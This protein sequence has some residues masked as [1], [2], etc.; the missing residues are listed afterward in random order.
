[1]LVVWRFGSIAT[2][3]A[4]LLACEDPGMPGTDAAVGPRCSQ[5]AAFGRITALT[6]LNTQN[7]DEQAA[8]S[9]DELTVYFSRDDNGGG[10]NGDYDIFQATR[11]SKTA[12][13]GA[14]TAVAGV[15]TTTAQ[16]REPR[17]TADGLTMYATTR[18]IPVGAAKFRVAFATRAS[19]ADSF[20]PLQDVPAINGTT[21]NDSDPFIS[22]DGRV[23]Y[24]AS[25][26]GGNYALY[27]SVQTAGV[28]SAPALVMG[29]NLETTSAEIT[30][31]L[32]EDELTL[33]FASSRPGKGSVDIFQANRATVQD[34]FGDPKP[35]N[36]LNGLDPDIPSWISADG[37]ELYFTRFSPANNLELA[38]TLRGM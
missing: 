3:L 31:L 17:V 34:P 19:T 32:S 18:P 13:F 33:Y 23:L 36:E 27:R 10:A 12:A 22:A 20:G 1:M 11:T 6:P 8:L 9:P 30:P 29:T 5:T 26:R 2:G 7:N 15:N 24:F 14:A 16:E 38:V 25:D 35:L 37:C 21:T 4:G 28:F